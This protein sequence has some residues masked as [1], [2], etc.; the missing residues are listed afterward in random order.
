MGAEWYAIQSKPHKEEALCGQL[1]ASELEVFYPKI[2]VNPV[3]PRARKIKAYF[4][5]YLFVKA[6]LEKTGLSMLQFTPFARG[7][8]S[9]DKEPA[10]VPE[11]LIVAI[12][13]KL[14]EIN[15]KGGEVMAALVPGQAVLITD[16]PFAGY[17]GI[18]DVRLSGSDRVK[19]LIE[20]LSKRYIPVELKVGQV[21]VQKKK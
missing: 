2:R 8:V 14:E 1:L 18:F 13:K 20:L 15:R 5:G 21:E 7:L 11:A 9:F 4:P 12:R 16:G 6:D 3:N 17:S 10:A 19:V